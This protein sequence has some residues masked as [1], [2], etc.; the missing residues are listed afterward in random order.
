[1]L[2]SCS[3]VGRVY[4]RVRV[5]LLLDLQLLHIG[6]RLRMATIVNKEGRYLILVILRV[7][8]IIYLAVLLRLYLVERWEESEVSIMLILHT[9]YFVWHGWALIIVCILVQILLDV[10]STHS[11]FVLMANV[12]SYTICTWRHY[13]PSRRVSSRRLSMKR[14]VIRS[15]ALAWP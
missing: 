10:M 9:L 4:Q 15:L 5:H 14:V 2:L 7:I 6:R 8:A 3:T 12:I 13:P 1:M 11:S